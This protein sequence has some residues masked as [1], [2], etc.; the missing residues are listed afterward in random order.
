MEHFRR[1]AVFKLGNVFAALSMAD[2]AKHVP[3]FPSSVEEVESFIVSL[4]LSRNLDATL[5][6]SSN[7]LRD[8]TLRF[9]TRVSK[10]RNAQGADVRKC[11]VSEGMLLKDLM[12]SI[13][14]SNHILELSNEHVESLRRIQNL[15]NNNK[16]ESDAVISRAAEFDM[17]E[18]DIMGDIS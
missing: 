5:L 3:P 1:S 2:V 10:F 8:T 4:I 13:E 11:L 6:H 7:E 16:G 15:K 12:Q 9:S 14:E 17:D 18:E